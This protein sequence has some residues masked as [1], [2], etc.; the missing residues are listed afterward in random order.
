MSPSVKGH[1]GA[2]PQRVGNQRKSPALD[3]LTEMHDRVHSCA[4][5][6][7]ALMSH[8]V[9]RLFPWVH[10]GV[11]VCSSMT[12]LPIPLC[13]TADRQRYRETDCGKNQAGRLGAA[14]ESC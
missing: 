14:S 13:S 1:A 11:I 9:F 12:S 5:R 6:H 8:S 10:G 4:V 2:S 7:F 3:R